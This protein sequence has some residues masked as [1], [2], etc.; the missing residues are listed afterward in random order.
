MRLHRSPGVSTTHR[1]VWTIAATC[2]SRTPRSGNLNPPLN[3]ASYSE[4]YDQIAPSTENSTYYDEPVYSYEP[5]PLYVHQWTNA[6]RSQCG[7]KGV[8][9]CKDFPI[10]PS[11]DYKPQNQTMLNLGNAFES[12]LGAFGDP[13]EYPSVRIFYSDKQL[14]IFSATPFSRQEVS[15]SRLPVL[16]S[17]FL[18]YF[19]LP[20]PHTTTC[21]PNYYNFRRKYSPHPGFGG[22]SNVSANSTFNPQEVANLLAQPEAVYLGYAPRACWIRV[23]TQ[24]KPLFQTPHGVNSLIHDPAGSTIDSPTSIECLPALVAM[25]EILSNTTC[26]WY[27]NLSTWSEPHSTDKRLKQTVKQ[28]S[29]R[30]RDE[31]MNDSSMGD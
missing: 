16:R 26:I 22:F 11:Y 13:N 29:A 19:F 4:S 1:R 21:P 18:L 17:P 6:L 3:T 20:H 7:Y 25:A 24:L 23:L 10:I 12:G 31:R 5:E 28:F 8:A 2:L 15:T 27:W 30:Q 9:P 14:T